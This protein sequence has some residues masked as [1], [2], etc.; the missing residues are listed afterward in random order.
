MIALIENNIKVAAEQFQLASDKAQGIASFDESARLTLKQR[1]AFASIRSGD[2]AKAEKLFRELIAAFTQTDGPESASVLRVR[3]NLAQA[4]MIQNKNQDAIRE[5][6][7]LY[8]LYAA[9]LGETHELTLQLLSTKAQCEG[10]LGLWD[11]A[12]RDDLK[13]HEL[14][15]GKQGP[16]SFFAIAT[17]SDAALAQCRGGKY[18]EGELNA[19]KAWE[20]AG[21]T[22]GPRAALTGAAA[23]TLASCLIGLDKLPE[24]SRLL[25]DIDTNAV[26]QLT[27]FPEWSANV[28]L[29]QAEIAYRQ[30]DLASARK[31]LEAARPAFSR[32]DAEVYQKQALEK[33]S[34]KLK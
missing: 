27:G 4:Y 34:A 17:L 29:A 19:R 21:K 32:A 7:S 11:D 28:T 33:L 9:K 8:P 6:G 10:A 26:A 2:G 14:A 13:V 30:G 31:L 5:T 3:L 12:V 1:L 20:V 23:D 24:A 22:F 15:V 16:T 18:A 25:G